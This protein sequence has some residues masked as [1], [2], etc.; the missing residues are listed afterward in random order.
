MDRNFISLFIEAK[1]PF[2]RL[3][4]LY[5][6]ENCQKSGLQNTNFPF[7]LHLSSLQPAFKNPRAKIATAPSGSPF[8]LEGSCTLCTIVERTN[9]PSRE[10]HLGGR[11]T[12]SL[13]N[14]RPRARSN[15]SALN[16]A[17]SCSAPS[18][19]LSPSTA[20]GVLLCPH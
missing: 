14:K 10:L 8:F 11:F 4:P 17:S 1:A 7:A 13:R 19:T 12:C 9:Q 20:L 6:R 15:R 2:A 5:V 16:H 3:A 18:A